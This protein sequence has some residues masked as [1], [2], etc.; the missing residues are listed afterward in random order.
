MGLAA[1]GLSLMT[2]GLSQLAAAQDAPPTDAAAKRAE[3]KGPD[4]SP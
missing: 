3:K 4:Y 1:I 2:D